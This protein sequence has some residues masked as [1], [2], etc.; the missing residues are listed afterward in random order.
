MHLEAEIPRWI[1]S[2]ETVGLA[3]NYWHSAFDDHRGQ[4]TSEKKTDA[5]S[6]S[7]RRLLP[8]RWRS[9]AHRWSRCNYRRT[10]GLPW[11]Q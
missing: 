2:T 9:L 4:P 8:N 3:S 11:P 7:T 5:R 6:A 10:D 1:C